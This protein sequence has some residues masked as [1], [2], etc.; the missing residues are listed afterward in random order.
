MLFVNKI[1]KALENGQELRAV[2]L[3]I[4]KAF[5]KYWHKGLLFQ[6]KQI[7]IEGLLLNW[8]ESCLS[9]RCQR[10]VVAGQT[11]EWRN[12][13]AG[14]PQGSVQGPILFLIFINDIVDS[15]KSDIFLFADDTS[16]LEVVNKPLSTA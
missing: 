13:A 5:D 14:V 11:S 10:V 12:I 15:V 7:G 8:F 3:D 6:L 16:I 1:L 4:S 2:F 9:N